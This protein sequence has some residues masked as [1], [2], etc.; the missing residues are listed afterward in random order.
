MN[1]IELRKRK[2]LP[3]DK[4]STAIVSVIPNDSGTA[5]EHKATL[6][7]LKATQDRLVP[8][9]ST[10]ESVE[11]ATYSATNQALIGTA[12]SLDLRVGDISHSFNDGYHEFVFV[13]HYDGDEYPYA[14]LAETFNV[15]DVNNKLQ[16]FMPY[17]FEIWRNSDTS[18]HLSGSQSETF[19]LAKVIGYRI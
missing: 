14:I 2:R 1:G 16:V 13:I 6:A 5:E 11:I 7:E 8:P 3:D 9:T 17:G 4:V 15:T 18:F 19:Y 12:N 10:A